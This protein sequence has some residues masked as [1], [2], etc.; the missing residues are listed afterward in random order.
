ML[1]V[2][3]PPRP[4]VRQPRVPANGKA[5]TPKHHASPRTTD[6]VAGLLCMTWDGATG[7][8]QEQAARAPAISRVQ[9]QTRA[10]CSPRAGSFGHPSEAPGLSSQLPTGGETT[11]RAPQVVAATSS[12]GM[13]HSKCSLRVTA[14]PRRV[15]AA[16]TSRS[17]SDPHPHRSPLHGLPPPP[18]PSQAHGASQLSSSSTVSAATYKPTAALSI[19]AAITA[20]ASSRRPI[21]SASPA[22]DGDADI[23]AAVNNNRHSDGAYASEGKVAARS[24][25]AAA[26]TLTVTAAAAAPATVTA[27]AGGKPR[28]ARGRPRRSRTSSRHTHTHAHGPTSASSTSAPKEDVLLT[29]PPPP[30]SDAASATLPH[31]PPGS[32]LARART[33]W[34]CN[35]DIYELLCNFEAHGLRVRELPVQNPPSACLLACAFL[36]LLP[37]RATLWAFGCLTV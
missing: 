19:N 5:V 15:Y 26:G 28:G 16:A 13:P 12:S 32:I 1:R 23:M 24:A 36:C 2:R 21:D 17:L 9:H 6:A 27:A 10:R 29:S 20:R 25:A 14:P 7:A 30:S 8:K 4:R 33:H 22:G 18:L 31:A 35:E 11:Q 3:A 34:L 37:R